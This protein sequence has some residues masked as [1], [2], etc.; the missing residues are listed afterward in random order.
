M[1]PRIRLALACAAAL[2]SVAASR[3]ATA[4]DAVAAPGA[5][6]PVPGPAPSAGH[7]WMPGH[8]ISDSGQWK[9]VAAHWELPPSRSS[10][11]VAGHWV[12]SDGKWAWVNGAWNVAQAPETAAAA[13]QPPGAPASPYAAAQV[14]TPSGPPPSVDGVYA[15]QQGDLAVEPGAVSVDY[16][17]VYYGAYYPGYA[18]DW[19]FYPGLGLGLGWVGGYWGHG[20]W[21]HGYGR[22]Y[23]GG[24]YSH[25]TGAV[26]GGHFYGR[27]GR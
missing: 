11:W 6:N 15:A 25:P 8:W 12:P 22:G 24:H 16:A 14:P 13:P 1:N 9:W 19:G 17:P 10:V 23:H 2:F 18:W 20:Y 26:S 4:D 21:G 3:A 27:G 5:E 7:V